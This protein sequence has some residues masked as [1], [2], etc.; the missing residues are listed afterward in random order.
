MKNKSLDF[1]SYRFMPTEELV[2][3]VLTARY[4]LGEKSWTFNSNTSKA[5]KKLEDKNLITW[6]NASDGESFLVF[7]TPLGKALMLSSKYYNPNNPVLKAA[8]KQI[9]K[10][11][12]DAKSVR[13]N[14]KNK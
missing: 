2:L 11:Y 4:R 7:F 8:K 5:L 1:N 12:K 10:I 9:N 6:K 14:L 3:E 13:K